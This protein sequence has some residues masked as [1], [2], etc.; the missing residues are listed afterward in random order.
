MGT[1]TG[2]T[3]GTVQEMMN[4]KKTELVEG[5]K[6]QFPI[7]NR[8]SKVVRKEA[9]NGKYVI[10]PMHVSGGMNASPRGETDNVVTPLPDTFI[11]ERIQLSEIMGSI[12]LTQDEMD[13]AVK[14]GGS[15]VGNLIDIKKNGALQDAKYKLN[16]FFAGDGTGKLARIA[17]VTTHDAS[18]A[19]YV[20][21]NTYADSGIP[22]TSR[23]KVGMLV[24]IYTVAGIGATDAWTIKVSGARVTSVA[25][26]TTFSVAYSSHVDVAANDF[27]F[28]H[29]SVNVGSDTYLAGYKGSNGLWDIVNSNTTTGTTLAHE[30]ASADNYNGSCRGATFQNVTR[31][32]YPQLNAL[33]RTAAEW[34]SGTKGTATTCDLSVINDTI[35]MIDEEGGASGLGGGQVTAIYMNGKTRDWMARLA[36]VDGNAFVNVDSGKIVPGLYI[37]SYRTSTG[38]I[39]PI[40]P[41]NTLPD[42][43][44]MLGDERDL[45][46]FEPESIDWYRGINGQLLFPVPG[47]RNLTF[48]AWVRW[49]GMLAARR[50]D[51][52]ARIEDIDV[53]Q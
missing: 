21:G 3:L 14:S 29:N 35:R 9:Y 31:A 12:G 7:L 26:A 18:S 1:W 42:G 4:E 20:A 51:N 52:W 22:G 5:F 28:I 30:Y 23:L 40:I 43:V 17:S 13:Y 37:E 33:I 8:V 15:A 49:K 10:V 32:T 6:Y 24:D 46:L 16:L 19:T 48:E 41:M 36:K 53:T 45:M 47:A 38:R 25:N 2:D 44:I 39:I 27:V 34:A 50:C 11:E